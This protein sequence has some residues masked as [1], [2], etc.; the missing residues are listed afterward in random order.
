MPDIM[1]K[2]LP[3][4]IVK[5]THISATVAMASPM[6]EFLSSEFSKRSPFLIYSQRG[7]IVQSLSTHQTKLKPDGLMFW[8]LFST[9]LV[10]LPHLYAN[11]VAEQ[12]VS[13]FAISLPY[14]NPSKLVLLAHIN[15]CFS[16]TDTR[17]FYLLL[18]F[19]SHQVQPVYCVSG[20]PCDR[21]VVHTLQTSLPQGLCS[22]HHKG[23]NQKIN[24]SNF[25]SVLFISDL[26]EMWQ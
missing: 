15:V 14:T 2:L 6:L 7:L 16:F 21:H 1:I 9:A 10:R 8:V 20:P 5:L 25:Y 17:I 22:V 24:P 13:V 19:Y 12:Y 18:L 3:A 11:F 26:I 23:E 4:L